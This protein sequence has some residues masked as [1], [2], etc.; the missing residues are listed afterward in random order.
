M[1]D[2][3]KASRCIGDSEEGIGASSIRHILGVHGIDSLNLIGIC[4]G[5]PAMHNIWS[6]SCAWRDGAAIVQIML[7]LPW[8]NSSNCYPENRLVR[9]TLG[10]GRRRVNLTNVVQPVLNIHAC[11]QGPPVAASCLDSA[12]A[13]DRKCA[14]HEIRERHRAQRNLREPRCSSGSAATHR[15]LAAHARLGACDA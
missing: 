9:G 15:R 4:Q 5:G 8:P 3:R 6:T 10:R 2:R 12:A 7:Q 13:T 11:D 14:L 1:L